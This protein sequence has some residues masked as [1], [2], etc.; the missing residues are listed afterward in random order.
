MTGLRG[1]KSSKKAD[2]PVSAVGDA[3][4]KKK[5]A[6]AD[7]NDDKVAPRA[8]AVAVASGVYAFVY[9]HH[10]RIWRFPHMA[11]ATLCHHDWIRPT[12]VQ[13]RG[14]QAD[15]RWMTAVGGAGGRESEGAREQIGGADGEEE[16]G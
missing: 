1:R 9:S 12:L 11:A 5:A 6:A 8:V 16:A 15:R 4:A 10:A 3:I 7:N 14:S 2:K 13:L